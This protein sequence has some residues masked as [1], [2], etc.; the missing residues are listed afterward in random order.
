ML[1]TILA[2]FFASFVGFP[3]L[4]LYLSI[5]LLIF[6][7]IYSMRG[8]NQQQKSHYVASPPDVYSLLDIEEYMRNNK[9]VNSFENKNMYIFISDYE[10]GLYIR[11]VNKQEQDEFFTITGPKDIILTCWAAVQKYSYFNEYTYKGLFYWFNAQYVRSRRQLFI[12]R[13]K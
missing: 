12:T 4:M 7:I 8:G 5:A 6:L 13:N 2:F 10:E 3:L 9:I 11:C 1:D